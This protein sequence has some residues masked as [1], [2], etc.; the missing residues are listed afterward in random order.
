MTSRYTTIPAT[1]D[2]LKAGPRGHIIQV[3]GIAATI[4]GIEKTA[5]GEHIIDWEQIDNPIDEP[6]ATGVIHLP[7]GA[8]VEC[9]SH[10]DWAN[11]RDIEVA[12]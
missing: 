4:T 3:D 6:P 1:G 8:T 12:R 11:Q 10:A 5:T 2:G 7:D 9:I